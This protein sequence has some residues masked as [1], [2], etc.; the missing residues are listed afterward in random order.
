MAI[1]TR[2]NDSQRQAGSLPPRAFLPLREP[3]CCESDD[4]HRSLVLTQLD[5]TTEGFPLTW[6]Y[7][8]RWRK[9]PTHEVLMLTLTEHEVTIQGEHLDRI[10]EH[11]RDNHGLHLR[12][13]DNRY[14]SVQGKHTLRISSITIEPNAKPPA[15]LK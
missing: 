5:G 8:W 10:L 2:V 3:G 11:L 4:R 1:E 13:K 6:L 14:L 12:I 15:E 9:H 7:R